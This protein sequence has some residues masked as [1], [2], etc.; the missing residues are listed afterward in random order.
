MAS[1][2]DAGELNVRE[3]ILTRRIRSIGT[4]TCPGAISPTIDYVDWHGVE[5]RPPR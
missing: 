3:L 4:E 5:P 2:I 1:V